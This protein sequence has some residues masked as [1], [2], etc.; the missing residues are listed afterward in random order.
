MIPSKI[1]LQS[2]TDWVDSKAYGV[3]VT[4]NNLAFDI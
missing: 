1:E 2:K 3:Y 4:Q